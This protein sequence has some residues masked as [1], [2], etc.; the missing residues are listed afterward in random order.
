MSALEVIADRF[1]AVNGGWMDLASG[2][3]VRLRLHAMSRREQMAW[4][5]SCGTIARL[6]HPLLNPLVDF[7]DAGRSHVFE[8]YAIGA[9]LRATAIERST[10]LTH[11]VRFLSANHVALTAPLAEALIRDIDAPPVNATAQFTKRRRPLGIIL[12][13]RA[14]IER[15]AEAIDDAGPGGPCILTVVGP[16]GSGMRTL[17]VLVARTARLA[18]YV[19]V[20]ADVLWRVPGV[21]EAVADR[22]LCLFDADAH[23]GERGD[24]RG[25]L[26]TLLARLGTS[27]P[28][29]HIVLRF[30]RGIEGCRGALEMEP[31]TTR[32]LTSMVYV[33]RDC[34]PTRAELSA[35]V[36]FSDGRPGA[37]LGR[38]GALHV[39]DEGGRVAMVHE[40]SPVY[41]VEPVTSAAPPR[42]SG[43]GRALRDAPDRAAR[44]ARRGRHASALRLLSRAGRVLAARGEHLLAAACDEATGWIERNRGRSARAEEAFERARR[45]GDGDSSAVRGA[46]GVGVV[47]TDLERFAEAEAALRGASAAAELLRDGCLARRARRALARC[48]FWQARYD[49]ALLL[50]QD[51]CR[52]DCSEPPD[53]LAA[54]DAYALTARIRIRIGDLRGSMAAASAAVRLAHAV[55]DPRLRALSARAMALVQIELGDTGQARDWIGRGLRAAAAAHLPILGVRLRAVRAA[56]EGDAYSADRKTA[57][58]RL[59]IRLLPPLVRREI[60]ALQRRG[61]AAHD[62]V[63]RATGFDERALRDLQSLLELT[64]AAADDH[65]ALERLCQSLCDELRAVTVQVV[66]A[67]ADGRLLARAGRPWAGD[68]RVIQRALTGGVVSMVAEAPEPRQWAEAV[69]YAQA[70]IAALGARWTTGAALDMRRVAALMRAAALAAAAPVRTL[71]DRA[72]AAAPPVGSDLIGTSP[73]AN[74][75][76]EAIARAARA[77]FPVLVEG[78]SGSGKELVARGIHRAGARRDRRLCTINCAAL[79]DE[80]VEAELFGHARGAFT[81]AV[82]DRPGLFEEADGGTLFLDEIG[83]L[84]ARAQAKLLRVLQDGEVRRVGENLPRRVDTRIVAATN[85]RLEDEVA[86]GRFRADVRFRL[87]VIRIVVPPLRERATDIPALALHFWTEATA[88]LGSAATLTPESLAALARYD[89]PGNVRELQNAIASLAVHAPRRGR[90]QPSMLPVRI[91]SA[92][93][94]ASS[95]HGQTFEAARQEFERRYV[96]AALA[97]AGGQRSRAA[98]ALGVS[99]QGLAKMLNRLR[100]DD[101]RT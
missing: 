82:G 51:D 36:R 46:I 88:R 35:A 72:P 99:R 74:T 20:S 37:F 70:P 24:D 33:D 95:P 87:D 52:S 67:D 58:D 11:A 53:P 50:L 10:L 41:V 43:I 64:H 39:D 60:E 78:E 3:F 76:R 90:V 59:R 34:G 63:L 86:A 14:V 49:E 9:A 54:A 30:R 101:S 92:A 6:R 4:D 77:P 45:R 38:L 80:L 17:Q 2:A 91:A 32:A 84:S 1:V 75:L 27:S 23:E 97:R 42:R 85:R 81:G 71:L 96:R 55:D 44:L 16:P 31:M 69:R 12:Q 62:G 40:S 56:C 73:A 5:D 19:A 100:I 22:T 48:L 66:A 57:E 47:W 98:R 94:L 29:R 8:A 28:R 65:A 7:G 25:P 61:G 13:P 89:W 26:A 79:S 21:G 68:V 93:T 18:G 15:I 83:E